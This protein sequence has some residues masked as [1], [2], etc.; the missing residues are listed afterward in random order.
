MKCFNNCLNQYE[1]KPIFYV[2]KI[3]GNLYPMDEYNNHGYG[4]EYRGMKDLP[5]LEY[6]YNFIYLCKRCNYQLNK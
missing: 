3:T 2:S 5:K 4:G 6:P 1:L